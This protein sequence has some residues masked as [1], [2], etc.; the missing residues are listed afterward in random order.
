MAKVIVSYFMIDPIEHFEEIDFQKYWLILQRRSKPALAVFG[1]VVTLATL[2]ALS[3]KHTYRA[4]GSLLIKTSRAYSLTGLGEDIGRLESLAVVNSPLDTQAR[5]VA[6]VP[7]LQET[8]NVLNLKDLQNKPLKVNDLL[9][10]LKIDTAK[11]TDI[12]QISY[13]DTNPQLAAKV[14]NTIIAIYTKINIQSNRSEAVSA[15]LFILKQLPGTEV[16]VR[17]AE[18]ALRK[19]RENNH[20]IVLQEE[21]TA[22]VKSISKFEDE[23][24]E[25]QAQLVDVTAQSEKLKKQADITSSQIVT[26]AALSEIP[27]TQTTLTQLQEAQSQLVVARTRFQ[28]GH[29]TVINLQ[30][31]IVALNRLLQQRIQEVVG[32]NQQVSLSNLQIGKQRQELITDLVRLENQRR[33]LEKRIATLSS[34]QSAYKARSQVLP[35]LEQ[36]QRELERKLKAA[37]TT[38]ERLLTKLQDIYVAENQNVANARVI[39]PALVPEIPEGPQKK[40]I[41]GAGGVAGMLLGIIAAFAIDL[42]DCS[43]K[44]LKEARDL[45]PY[46]LLGVIPTFRLNSK[47]HSVPRV[48]NR[49]IPQFPLGNAY[50]MLQGNLKFL[51]SE[52]EL[53]TITVTS[54]VSKEGKSEVS[55]NLAVTMAEAGKRVLLVDADMRHPVQHQ[56]WNLTNTVG[57]SNVLSEKVALDR[58]IQAVRQNLDV[59]PTG[60]LPPNPMALLDSGQMTYLITVFMRQYDF[61]IFDT[62]ALKGTMDAAVLGKRTDGILLVVRPG[63]VDLKSANGA[64]EFLI[65][66]GQYVLGMVLNGVDMKREPDSYF[67][68]SRESVEPVSRSRNSLVARKTPSEFIGESDRA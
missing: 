50:Q 53:K 22:A 8:I 32:N 46:T 7:V 41:I 1:V 44:T 39:S 66:S 45:L 52:Q 3:L 33:G 26:F 11:G 2:F 37:Q 34:N 21:A 19:F 55:A 59:L 24:A 25:A 16:S 30:E 15:R 51:R 64:K 54:S 6:S 67:Y 56:I 38:Y 28:P 62:P 48:I 58:A 29:P 42:S 47:N 13:K 27:G 10:K 40:L 23:I 60:V 12:L 65:Q 68:Y 57:L 5:I 17:I 4:E 31:K 61:V 20:V 36:N 35:K 14:V 63:V 49:D 18:S 43:V 9:K